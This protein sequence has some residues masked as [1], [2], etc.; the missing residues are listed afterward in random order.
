MKLSTL[1]IRNFRGIREGDLTLTDHNVFVGANNSGKT[2]V[3]EALA[4]LFG[5]DRMVRSLTEHDFYGGNPGP[6]DRI[7][8]IATIIGFEGNDTE[9]HPTW[10][11]P[12]RAVPKWLHSETGQLIPEPATSRC[13]LACQ[14]GFAGRFDRTDLEVET[15]RYFVDDPEEDVFLE[16]VYN[17]VPPKLLRDIGFFLVPVSRTW[18][19]VASFS[20]EL[21]R[22]VLTSGDGLPAQAVLTERDRLRFPE[23]PVEN[24][25]KIV[26]VIQELNEEL[27]GFFPAAPA[28][29]LRVTATDSD[30]VMEAMVPHY[31]FASEAMTI[32]ARRHGTGLV[33]LQSLVLLFHFGRRRTAAG[34]GFWM[35][36]EEPELHI[37]PPLQRRV[38]QR[39]QSLSAQTFIS[40]HSPTVAS[41]SDP[42][43]LHVLRNRAGVLTATPLSPTTAQ[44]EDAN[45]VRKLF[46]LHRQST[47][48]ALMHDC[49]LIPEGTTDS[50]LLH[51]LATAVDVN[52]R[53]EP[54]SDS[55][56]LAHVGIVKTTDA[57]VV[58]TYARLRD[59]HPRIACLVDGDPAGDS[60]LAG[61]AAKETQ[62]E[63][64]LRWAD[65]FAIEDLFGWVLDAD[66]GALAKIDG[67][68]PPPATTAELVVR[69]K[70]KDRP[71]GLKANRVAYDAVGQAIAGSVL[72]R[73]RARVLLNALA[74]ECLGQK[75]S[76]FADRML[77]ATGSSA[78]LRI[79]VFQ[80]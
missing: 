43:A 57:Q 53:W 24:D 39:L 29:K 12:D 16:G 72:A 52:Q 66:P 67:I 36:L 22:R 62:P 35:A 47:I 4:L 77:P 48:E 59:L 45:S 23:A 3:I 21:F 42:K 74:D 17:L 49:L 6:T 38:V 20:S 19:R 5:R 73:E 18:D 63:C 60:Y 31:A 50:D 68:E 55:Q 41:M 28:L 7:R 75:S 10:F 40:S 34:Q 30:S 78:A 32:P 33:S 37:P 44:A 11:G 46:E 26:P 15:A 2:T 71:D 27:R 64:A 1:S 69:L 9:R 51:L 80:P 56:F 14:I 70:S 76:S 54:G 25:P 8:L 13:V 61:L 65:G 58:A 79:R